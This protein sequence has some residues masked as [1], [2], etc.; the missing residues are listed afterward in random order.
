MS[1]R[2][3]SRRAKRTRS[4]LYNHINRS[5]ALAHLAQYD[6]DMCTIP[7]VVVNDPLSSVK[8]KD[9]VGTD[10]M[11]FDN[12][13][14][15]EPFVASDSEDSESSS[16][17]GR[18]PGEDLPA[19]EWVPLDQQLHVMLGGNFHDE[20]SEAVE[21]T[22]TREDKGET[23]GVADRMYIIENETEDKI[24]IDAQEQAM[25]DLLQLCQDAGTSLE[26]FDNLVTLLR[27][28]GKKGFDI[29]KASRRQ[30]FL[31]NLRKKIS[32]PRPSIVQVGPYQ[33]P[34]FNLLEQ[35]I[36]LLKSVIFDDVGNLCVNLSPDKRFST[37][38]ATAADAFVEVCASGWYRTTDQEFVNDHDLEFLLPL[39]FYIDETG[40]DAFQRY[41]LEPLMFT[42]A[43]IRR[44][45]REKSGAWRH[46]G[47]VPKVSDFDTSLEGLQMYHDCLSA[48]LAD[49][50]ELQADPP[51][52]ELNLGGMTKRVKII[53][54]VA[55][56]MGDQKSQDTLCARKKSN[57]GGAARVHRRC[58]CSS[59]HGSDPSTKCQ[60]VSKPILD[61]L[62]D[63]SFEDQ[64]NSVPM[65]TV[66][67][68]LP[69]DVRGN[70]EKHK[71]AVSFIK[72]RSRLAR[73]ILGRTYTTHAIRNAFDC[74]GFGTNHNKI[75]SATLD[76]P[77][78]FCNSGFFMYMGQVAYLGM[79]D[80]ER[81]D[82]ESIV[83]AQ[84]RG[85]RSSVRSDYPRGRT[86][87]GYTNM[88]LLT[89]DE[90]VG[91]NFTMLLALH[92][93]DAKAIMEKAIKRQQTKYMTFHVPKI[94]RKP[95][96][97]ESKESK[98]KTKKA[99]YQQKPPPT[100]KKP[101]SKSKK[102][103]FVALDGDPQELEQF[104]LR[105]HMY[106]A[107]QPDNFWPRTPLSNKFVM[108]HLKKH[109]L[110]FI[111]DQ[112]YD[113]LQL[114]YL[115]VES[116]K[117]LRLLNDND[118]S[119][120]PSSLVGV[121]EGYP[122]HEPGPLEQTYPMEE[123]YTE[124][125]YTKPNTMVALDEEVMEPDPIVVD[126]ESNVK[127]E[128]SDRI[129]SFGKEKAKKKEA[130]LVPITFTHLHSKEHDLVVKHG[131]IKPVV[132]GVGNTT[133]ILCGIPDY[134]EFLELS[135]CMH[136][137]L[138]YSAELPDDLRSDT[139]V[140]ERGLREF[141][142]L[143]RKFIYRGDSSVDTD[144]CKAHCFMHLL[145]NT[146][147]YGD[148]MQYDSGKGERGLK[149]WAKAVSVTAQKIGLDTF[150]FQTIM[151]V[152]DR[153]LLSRASDIVERQIRVPQEMAENA[154]DEVVTKRKLPH[155]RYYRAQDKVVAVS[156][157]GKESPTSTKSGAISP[158]VIAHLRKVEKE[159]EVVNIWCELKVP[160]TRDCTKSQLL[161]A[162]PNLDNFGGFFDWVDA[163]FD[164]F[165]GAEQALDE[166]SYSENEVYVAPAK[167][168]AFYV[169]A[170][171]EECV[172]V[173][174]VEWSD[175]KETALGN[176]RLILNYA[177]EFQSSGWPTIRKIKLEDIYRPL[178]VIERKRSKTPLPPRT[179]TARDRKEYVVSVI[180]PRKV[181]AEMFYWW[182]K[183]EVE[184]WTDEILGAVEATSDSSDDEAGC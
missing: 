131:R 35:I 165:G 57:G 26:F 62:R 16:R 30:T 81:E 60:P 27:R 150:L 168:L 25:L 175:G 5:H 54:E 135:L 108:L 169:D 58:M 109:G 104:P 149:Q 155:F 38:Q 56:V 181:W 127:D 17:E 12:D 101:S 99:K 28:H 179:T 53:L 138:H 159:M 52:V 14:F 184:P 93:D 123:Y 161:R 140:F 92:N 82:F 151:R 50:E 147:E 61:R 90:K 41:P 160:R 182:A 24:E 36:D 73:D 15:D 152:A 48:I 158:N 72:R 7:A 124:R 23:D 44:H 65:N 84:L 119:Y 183:E 13:D 43:L 75:L 134:V 107:R 173:H 121:I 49:L 4:H 51:I 20:R 166:D 137:Y 39:I 146:V 88:T 67:S 1:S 145:F 105:H 47:F 126:G 29:R 22:E 111:L 37:Y 33:V 69:H 97:D 136:A 167:L 98:E 74:I 79:Q 114:E 148:P 122:F 174:S 89:A 63:I 85:V 10:E 143:F 176:T 45:M 110:S 3:T 86:S 120:P 128:F 113:Q 117:T 154:D 133:A 9:M 171:G 132:K 156:R 8:K 42:F 178:Y 83:L 163:E 142:R 64:P 129:G 21:V 96:F 71:H 46:A 77:L 153:L 19:D 157:R 177:L 95:P 76:D 80:K 144:T 87:K 162:H 116:W 115:F 94:Q 130:E 34:K 172:I 6:I 112:D 68:E 32:C 180:K 170:G 11:Q 2:G 100:T 59:M 141:M 125:L 78:H 31:D 102:K 139:A 164:V 91:M 70:V 55:F 118:K 103:G 18:F 40:T 106:F 66:N